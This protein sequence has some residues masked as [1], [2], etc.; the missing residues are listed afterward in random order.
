MRPTTVALAL[1]AVI[2]LVP[3]TAHAKELAGARACDDDGC[4]TITDRST[5]RAM[6]G[7]APTSAPATGAPFHRVRMT[8]K[9]PG[10]KDHS[11]TMVYVPAQGLMRFPGQF[12]DY[13][14]LAATPR[15]KRALD[16]LVR[17][18]EPLPARRLGGVGEK[19]PTAQVHKVVP[20]PAAGDDD[21]GGFPWTLLLIPAGLAL[22][23]AGA[24]R[25]TK[26]RAARTGAHGPLARQRLS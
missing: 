5:L 25:V 24:R 7:G 23:A 10:D 14:W 11:Y 21:G 12:G 20:A 4:R 19:E 2:A 9:V 13:D 3:T 1:I 8:V 22:A 16:R 17:G 15:A 6:E 18:L 26:S